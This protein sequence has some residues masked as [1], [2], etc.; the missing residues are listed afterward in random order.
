MFRPDDGPITSSIELFR[1]QGSSG[2]GSHTWTRS[3]YRIGL[4]VLFEIFDTEFVVY[5][6]GRNQMAIQ[7]MLT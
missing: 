3:C 6:D 5:H 7:G 2:S 1:A 4:D